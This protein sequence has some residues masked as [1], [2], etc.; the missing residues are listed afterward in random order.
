MSNGKSKREIELQ[1]QIQH[2]TGRVVHVAIGDD[3]TPEDGIQE[4]DWYQALPL[5]VA[6]KIWD[7][8]KTTLKR[9]CLEGHV[10]SWKPGY[11]HFISAISLLRKLGK[12][13]DGALLLDKLPT[14]GQK[15]DIA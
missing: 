1:E 7:V 9:W 6:A 3:I 5:S 11:E 10:I 13:Q 14:L 4:R 12:P 15:L 2:L 8:P